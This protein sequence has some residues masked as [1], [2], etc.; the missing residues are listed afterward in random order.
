[1]SLFLN[2]RLILFFWASFLFSFAHAEIIEI[3]HMKELYD[4]LKPNALI[5]FDID[6]TLMAPVQEL[7]NDQWF[8]YQLNKYEMQGFDK[9]TALQKTLSEWTAIQ[10]VTKMVLAEPGIDCIVRQLQKQGFAVMGLTTRALDI[11]TCTIRHLN[12]LNIDLAATAPT[13]KEIFFM[14]GLAVLYRQGIL[15]TANTDKGEALRKFL[16][17]ISYSPQCII[18]INDKGSHIVPV[19]NFCSQ[20]K[21]PFIGLRYGYLDNRVRNFR[22]E[23][24]EVQFE[25]FGHIL[26]DES[27]NILLQ[28]TCK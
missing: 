13:Q 23:I 8:R 15:F 1:M 19:E 7:G 17:A 3:H 27:A 26:S 4:H 6:N 25:C 28:K 18:F 16:S 5:I 20:A 22:P 10:H 21:T 12:K 11:S 24:A 9:D 2:K 14:N